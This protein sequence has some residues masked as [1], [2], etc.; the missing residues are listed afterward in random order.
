MVDQESRGWPAVVLGVPTPDTTPARDQYL[1]TFE[2]SKE[3]VGR[4]Y[5]TVLTFPTRTLNPSLS[6]IFLSLTSTTRTMLQLP[7]R[8]QGVNAALLEPKPATIT[9]CSVTSVGLPKK[10]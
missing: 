5:S 1:D 3:H 10:W 6:M 9:W 8:A 7:K 2:V 4:K